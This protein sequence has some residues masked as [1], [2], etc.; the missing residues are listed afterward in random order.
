MSAP[1]PAFEAALRLYRE[2]RLEEALPA[3]D[4]LLAA[5]PGLAIARSLR[6]MVRCHLGDFDA[7]SAD[8]RAAVES[9]PRDAALHA[10]LGVILYVQHRLDEARAALKRALVLA[11][12]HPESLAAL[13]L[14]L[15]DQGDFAGAERAA[16]TALAARPGYPEARVNL[17]YAL[18]V[19][20]KFAEGW[21]AVGFRPH[22]RV[23]LR[24]PGMGVTVPHHDALPDKPAAI[25]VHG[26][27]GL[28]DTLF[29]LRFVPQL[30]ALGHRL[31]FWGDTRLHAVLARTGHFEHFL[32]PEAA[33]GPG[34]ALLWAGDLPRLLRAHDAARFPPALALAPDPAR[35]AAWRERFD[36][37]GPAPRLGLTWRAGGVRKGRIALA[38]N[39]EPETLGR[40]LAGTKATFVSLQRQAAAGE[41]ETIAQALG[42]PVHDAGIAND[43]LE[44]ALAAVSLLDDYVGVSNTNMHLRA[45]VGGPARV[46]IPFPPE[47][48]WLA[49][50]ERS[51]WFPAWP[52][53]RQDAGGGWDAALARLA[54]ELRP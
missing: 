44:D 15:R 22:A 3:F 21:D 14:V 23:N 20:G 45:G 36:A 28:G 4:A 6:G 38:K 41:R 5:D 47:W 46:L 33:P 34:L 31:A 18:L 26:E 24:D 32:K 54:S 25:I 10:N 40:A 49:G 1:N 42:A 11:P 9:S 19:Q 7:G 17:G 43:D 48:R 52:L 2:G 51:P 16:R 30:R 37:W 53:Y 50:A 27:Q 29:Y 12:N 8:L 13:S 39:V 35:V